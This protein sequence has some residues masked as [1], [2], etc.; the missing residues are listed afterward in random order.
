MREQ[1]RVDHG[2]TE[3]T[4]VRKEAGRKAGRLSGLD[5]FRSG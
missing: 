3:Y 4:V 1:Q 5:V 2:F